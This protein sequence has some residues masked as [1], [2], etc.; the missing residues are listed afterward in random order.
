[1]KAHLKQRRLDL[2]HAVEFRPGNSPGEAFSQPSGL[3]SI[4]LSGRKFQPL[5]GGF[6]GCRAIEAAG[7]DG[8]RGNPEVECWQED[9]TGKASVASPLR[10]NS[11]R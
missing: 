5:G 9:N 8:Q 6:Q 10:S 4:T 2:R 7:C 1:L 11:P 3:G